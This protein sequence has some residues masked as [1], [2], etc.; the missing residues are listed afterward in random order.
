MV[1]ILKNKI[2]TKSKPRLTDKKQN[3]KM[4]TEIIKIFKNRK[5]NQYL[6]MEEVI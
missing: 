1:N 2:Y 3:I 4:K 5:R 6:I